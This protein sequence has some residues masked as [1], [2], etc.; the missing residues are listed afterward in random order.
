[1]NI[2]YALIGVVLGVGL[3]FLGG[4][5]AA[6]NKVV[7]FIATAVGMFFVAFS[8]MV[9]YVTAVPLINGVLN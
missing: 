6:S 8:L 7:G 3:L 4:R 2:A 5:M 9:L 1:M